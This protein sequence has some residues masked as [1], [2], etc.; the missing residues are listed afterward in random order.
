MIQV[1]KK[2]NLFI[3]ED[4]ITETI[5]P[6]LTKKEAIMILKS[7]KRDNPEERCN[8]P[9]TSD[10]IKNF[11]WSTLGDAEQIISPIIDLMNQTLKKIQAELKSRI[12]FARKHE[13]PDMCGYSYSRAYADGLMEAEMLLDILA[14]K[15]NS[16]LKGE[17]L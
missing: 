10:N 12:E 4:T 7:Y 2:N 3:I 9:I 14:N 5:Y 16:E 17:Q 8:H 6:N 13:F 15:V 11:K 1:Y